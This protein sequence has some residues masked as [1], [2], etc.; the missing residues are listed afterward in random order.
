MSLNAACHALVLACYGAV[1]C[2]LVRREPGK[3]WCGEP[4]CDPARPGGARFG[5]ASLDGDGSGMA[6]SGVGK[7][8]QGSLKLG[9]MCSGMAG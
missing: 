8:R 5:T 1:R 6:R 4:G 2:G 3:T 9:R 7:Q